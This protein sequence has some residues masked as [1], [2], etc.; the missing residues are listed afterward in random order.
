[1]WLC[2]VH[3]IIHF[4]SA[5]LQGNGGTGPCTT[6]EGNEDFVGG[7]YVRFDAPKAKIRRSWPGLRGTVC[8]HPLS[9]S[10]NL[11][12]LSVLTAQLPSDS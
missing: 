10:F 11:F 8:F 9:F 7:T 3:F 12:A 4:L 1:M 2:Y 5:S 6:E